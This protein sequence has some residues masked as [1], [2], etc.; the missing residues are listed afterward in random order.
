MIDSSKGLGD[1]LV[2]YQASMLTGAA[3]S[4]QLV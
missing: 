2:R 3:I 4:G 1:G